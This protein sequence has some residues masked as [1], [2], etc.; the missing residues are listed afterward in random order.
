MK[1]KLIRIKTD[2]NK[3]IQSLLYSDSN[4]ERIVVLI[5]GACMNFTTGISQ[6]IPQLS[7]SFN[8]YDFLSINTRAHDI[9]YI[10]NSYREKDG[11]AWQTLD[12]NRYDLDAVFS[13][14]HEAGYREI[15][16]CGHSWG[17]LIGL[18][19]IQNFNDIIDGLILLS[20]TVSY[21]LLLEVNYRDDILNIVEKAKKM[22]L[23][24]KPDDIVMTGKNSPLPFMSAKT[25][26]DFYYS[27]F[28]A[29]RFLEE[30]RC[31]TNII[32]GSLEHKKLIAM[33]QNIT[34]KN[35]HVETHI[36]SGANHF[37][38]NH[39]VEVVNVIDSILGGNYRE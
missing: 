3:E 2:D 11:W 38:S 14:L 29:Q 33:A 23:E 30:V 18:D 9:G 15:I 19:Y 32:V 34:K 28:D 27:S 36:I 5:H 4:K 8:Y 20:P 21:K 6:F 24:K 1:S 22:V 17:G 31:K 26:V 13:Y 10:V 7:A 12:K 35:C 37:Y 25:I 16:L 39:E